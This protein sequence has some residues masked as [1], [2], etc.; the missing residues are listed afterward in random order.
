MHRRVGIPHNLGA[1][2]LSEFPVIHYPPLP[3]RFR[4][5]GPADRIPLLAFVNIY[6]VELNRSGNALS[7]CHLDIIHEC[8]R[9]VLL[10]HSYRQ[11]VG[12]LERAD[13]IR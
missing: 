6:P 10:P 1:T 3:D 7:E 13:V 2:A 9:A 11:G 5:K 12:Y 4:V 8:G